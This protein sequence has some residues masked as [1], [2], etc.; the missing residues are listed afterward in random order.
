M[1]RRGGTSST[2]FSKGPSPACRQSPPPAFP[3]LSNSMQS[4]PAPALRPRSAEPPPFQR[5]AGQPPGARL[6][7]TH[8]EERDGAGGQDDVAAERG[9]GHRQAGDRRGVPA[10]VRDEPG[11]GSRGGR[12]RKS[13]V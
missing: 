8:R 12:D 11:R 10:P 7:G 5:L 1:P 13:V 6:V 9:D 4:P 3:H 2:P